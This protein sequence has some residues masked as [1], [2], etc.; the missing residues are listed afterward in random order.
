MIWHLLSE[1]IRP[2]LDSFVIVRLKGSPLL[3]PL[4]LF[5][6]ARYTGISW[7]SMVTQEEAFFKREHAGK[8]LVKMHDSEIESWAEL[9]HETLRGRL[10]EAY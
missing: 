6:V 3:G 8:R 9:S 5:R 4:S 1:S 10:V 2:S 7:E